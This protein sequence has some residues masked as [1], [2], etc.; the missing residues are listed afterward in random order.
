M[1]T[2]RRLALVLAYD[3][4]DFA[5]WQ[6]QE[7]GRRTV[8]GELE[9]GLGRLLGKPASVHAASRTDAGVH[10][11]AQVAHVDVPDP[12]R[13]LG[14]ELRRR[15]NGVLPADLRVRAV[16]SMDPAFHARRSAIAK[17]Y[18]YRLRLAP[19]DDPLTARFRAH[20]GFRVDPDA[21]RVASGAFLGRRDF[22]ALRSEGSSARTTVRE[23]TRCEVR[24]VPPEVDV[25]VEGSGFLRHMVRALV[26][27]LVEVGRGRRPAAW[28]EDVLGA[29]DR[30]AAGP[31]VEAKGLHL[32]G[33]AY[34][35]PHQAAL[36][37]ALAAE[38]AREE[39]VPA[40][41]AP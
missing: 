2:A 38:L 25:L 21:M 5:G 31:N 23:V 36:D 20:V 17:R 40:G 18:E 11:H 27:C 9:A 33:V 32:V 15:L 4:T 35:L 6:R 7:D 3:G 8:Q 13:W 41:A 22:A 30:G 1:S 26:G 10:A 39:R 37:A 24:G 29:A 16:A 14:L 19:A 34:G 28:I 12:A